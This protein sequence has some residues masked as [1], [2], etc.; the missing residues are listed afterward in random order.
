MEPII[1]SS[2]EEK[3]PQKPKEAALLTFCK[4][5]KGEAETPYKDA[6]SA[7]AC[8]WDIERIAV[9]EAERESSVMLADAKEELARVD[10]P[11]TIVDTL[12]APILEV[13]FVF[14]G[15]QC[16]APYWSAEFAAEF[17]TFLRGG[18]GSNFV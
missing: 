9:R 17:E 12:P 15:K 6:S 11:K 4:Y 14:F 8:F 10:L 2:T 3:V 16:S 5:F 7:E 1:I 13:A 18:Y